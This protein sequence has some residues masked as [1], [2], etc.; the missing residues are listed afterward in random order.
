MIINLEQIQ[1]IEYIALENNL[2]LEAR[3]KQDYTP[4]PH[5][6]STHIQKLKTKTDLSS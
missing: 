4:T 3:Q 6:L 1:D 2:I 5:P